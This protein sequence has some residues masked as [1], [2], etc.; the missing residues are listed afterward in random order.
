MAF[1][2]TDEEKSTEIKMGKFKIL[3][4]HKPEQKELPE[5][6]FKDF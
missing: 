2:Q 4:P 5:N 3:E 1:K 6:N